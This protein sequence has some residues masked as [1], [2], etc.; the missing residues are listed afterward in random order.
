MKIE[1]INNKERL[2]K[3]KMKE[4]KKIET[5]EEIKIKKKRDPLNL[6]RR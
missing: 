6:E 1:I 2:M 5:G 4:R 3:Q